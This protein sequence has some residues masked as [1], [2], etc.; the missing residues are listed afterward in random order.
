MMREMLRA[1]T[2]AFE[3]MSAFFETAT[4]VKEHEQRYWECLAED[5]GAPSGV[6]LKSEV[7]DGN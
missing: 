6:A 7:G 3:A 1:A 2:R 4:L 5:A